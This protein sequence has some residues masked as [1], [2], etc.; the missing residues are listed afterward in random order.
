MAATLP[1]EH[2]RP[3][4]RVA[5]PLVLVVEDDYRISA[6]LDRALVQAGYR[7]TM[8]PDGPTALRAAEAGQPD[9]V[10]LDVMLPGLDGLEVA[11]RLRAAGGVPILMLTAR[12]GV[13]DR[14]QGLD[15]GADDYLVKPF[16]LEELLARLRALLRGRAL[17]VAETRRGV[18]SYADI[19]LD[20]DTR[21]V[22][23]GGR[24]VELRNKA[25][26]LLAYCLRNPDRVVSRRELL[27]EV[28]G[29]DFLGDSNVIEVTVGQLRQKLEAAGEARVIQTVR[30]I[31]YM[32]RLEQL[33]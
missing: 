24:R 33:G 3:A 15:A 29:Y 18:L 4:D 19:S 8:A 30:P 11:R 1:A 7:V 12:D 22:I 20:Q 2:A 9:V 27:E 25:F 16:A 32:L 14:V 23:R 28:W 5:A 13:G 10:V 26:E 17:A 6:F 31:G 21:E